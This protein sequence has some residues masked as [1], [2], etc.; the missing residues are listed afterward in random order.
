MDYSIFL[1]QLLQEE[2]ILSKKKKKKVV[3]IEKRPF[4]SFLF[5]RDF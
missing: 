5:G 1:F 2:V 4:Y 3:N